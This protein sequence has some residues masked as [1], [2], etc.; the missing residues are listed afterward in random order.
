M[1]KRSNRKESIMACMEHNCLKCDHVWFNNRAYDYC[2][3][4][5]SMQVSHHWDEVEDEPEEE[6]DE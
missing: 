1:R 4:C 2:S 5:G 3:K 6:D